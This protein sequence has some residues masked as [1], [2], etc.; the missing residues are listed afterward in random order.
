MLYLLN[1]YIKLYVH[2]LV[3]RSSLLTS[4]LK[5]YCYF[6]LQKRCVES[7]WF[8]EALMSF[9]SSCSD[10][11]SYSSGQASHSMHKPLWYDQSSWSSMPHLGQS[12]SCQAT[13]CCTAYPY[14]LTWMSSDWNKSHLPCPCPRLV[15][16]HLFGWRPCMLILYSSLEHLRTS[17]GFCTTCCLCSAGEFR[18]LIL[19]DVHIPAQSP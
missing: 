1:R 17:L 15:W 12:P 2:K 14:W 18:W 9:Y 13:T 7:H 4:G 16:P 10:T 5:S 3:M 19:S 6:R 8:S 11:A